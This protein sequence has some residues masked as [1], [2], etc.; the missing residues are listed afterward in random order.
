L[1]TP[2]PSPTALIKVTGGKIDAAT[3]QTELTKFIT[4]DW[5]REALPHGDDSFLVEFPGAKFI[6]I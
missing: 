4:A 6:P 3:V 2:K 5:N 1:E